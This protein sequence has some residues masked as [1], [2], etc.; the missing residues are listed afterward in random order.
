M[1]PNSSIYMSMIDP[2]NGWALIRLRRAFARRGRR[3]SDVI[4]R[5]KSH[6]RS[7]NL[8]SVMIILML[9]AMPAAA[10]VLPSFGGDRAGTS[11]FQFLKIP[12]DPRGA[13]L[14]QTV[15]ANAF[16]ASA[17]FWNPALAAHTEGFQIGLNHAAYFADVNI[18]FLAMTYHLAGPDITLGASIQTLDSGEMN[19]TTEF[20]PFGTGET[21]RLSDIAAGLT[22]SQR[23][24]DLFSYGL[25]TKY[26]RE[27]VAGIDNTTIVFDLGI[28]Y[29]IGTTGAQMAVSI[30]NFGF[31]GRPSGAIDRTVIGESSVVSESSFESVTPPTTFMM[32]LSYDLFHN[33][34]RNDLLFSAQLNNPNDNAE[35]WNIGLEYTWNQTLVLRSGYRFGVEEYNTPSAGIGLHIPYFGPDLRFDYG[36]SKLERLGTIHRVGLNLVM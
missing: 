13:A 8:F 9:T 28:F 24:T 10:Q 12:T 33:D 2:A 4:Q 23:L 32:G 21:F 3:R 14:G 16:D 31:D 26:V 19:V 34:A 22:L 5:I 20:Q 36:F 7:L 29:R 35:N 30:R 17:L 27:S 15:V 6:M 18:E 25:T 11:G 1:V